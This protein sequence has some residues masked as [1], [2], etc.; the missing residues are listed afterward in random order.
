MWW[1]R[2]PGTNGCVRDDGWKRVV[3]KPCAERLDHSRLMAT[4]TG[5]PRRNNNGDGNAARVVH[6]GVE[7][8]VQRGE[9]IGEGAAE[10]G[11][12]RHE[13]RAQGRVHRPSRANEGA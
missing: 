1:M 10:D 6:R 7:G 3:L 9:A 2:N 13:P 4:P 11:K 12:E 8:S 5:N